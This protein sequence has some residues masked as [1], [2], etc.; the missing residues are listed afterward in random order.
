VRETTCNG[1]EIPAGHW[2][3]GAGTSDGSDHKARLSLPFHGTIDL[4][5]T[6]E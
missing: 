4:R 6:A 5:V 3:Y 1:A 2:T